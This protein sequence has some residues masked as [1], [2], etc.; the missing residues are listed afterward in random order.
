MNSPQTKTIRFSSAVSVTV[1][2]LALLL[3]A[4]VSYGEEE[5]HRLHRPRNVPAALQ[6]PAGNELSFH[7]TGVGAQ[8]YTWNGSIWVFKAP[9]AVLFGSKEDEKGDMVGIH[10][11]GPT[12]ESNSGSAV[13][14]TKVAAVTVDPDAI[15][16]LKLQA[17]S[18]SGVGIFADTTYIQRLDTVGGLAPAA[19]GS[20]VGEEAL[21]PY[22]AEYF[23]YRASQH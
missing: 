12:W 16:W 2:L 6:V 9:H 15:P 20:S 11:A 13:V 8:I 18:T 17:K 7:A 1:P 10:F 4:A 21:V 3:L 23:F 14:G 19:P 22:I 5:R